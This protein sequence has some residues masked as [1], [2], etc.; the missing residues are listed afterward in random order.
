[1]VL[2]QHSHV[3]QVTSNMLCSSATAP[4]ECALKSLAQRLGNSHMKHQDFPIFTYTSGSTNLNHDEFWFRLMSA[5]TTTLIKEKMRPL[6]LE[7][8]STHKNVP[9]EPGIYFPVFL[10]TQICSL[11]KYANF[12]WIKHHVSIFSLVGFDSLERWLVTCQNVASWRWICNELDYQQ[13]DVS[14]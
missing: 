8:M 10:L 6:Y 3:H 4:A 5:K 1:M 12:A 9:E 11:L 13:H 2:L 7:C 14:I